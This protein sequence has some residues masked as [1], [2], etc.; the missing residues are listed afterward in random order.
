MF[1]DPLADML[2]RIRNAHKAKFEIAELPSSRLKTGVANLL[3]RE[4]Y[5]KDFKVLSGDNNKKILRISLR[6]DKQ[7]QPVIAGLKRVSKPSLRVYAR[8]DT[9]PSVLSGLGIA[10]L[11]TSKG[12]LTDRDARDLKV[13]GEVLC[14][15]W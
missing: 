1:T 3:K 13:G 10:I 15:V 2:T 4:G 6:Y 5:I 14:F 8:K 9:I 12:I 11:S 7:N